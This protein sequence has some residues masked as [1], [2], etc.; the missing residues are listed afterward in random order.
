MQ[1]FAVSFVGGIFF[2]VYHIPVYS[3][4]ANEAE[5]T[6]VLEF[7]TLRKIFVSLGN[8][9]AVGALAVFYVLYGLRTGFLASFTLGALA[10]VMMAAVYLRDKEFE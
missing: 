1:V 3:S 4:F 2:Q 8:I 5:D 7:Y 9:L 6:E 10:T